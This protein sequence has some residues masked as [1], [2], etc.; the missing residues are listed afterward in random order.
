ML[1]GTVS[2]AT[3]ITCMF[4]MLKGTVSQG[5]VI[6]C[7]FL[8]LK[9]TVSQATLIKCMFLM[10]KGYLPQ[11]T[12][13]ILGVPGHCVFCCSHGSGVISHRAAHICGGGH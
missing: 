10:L 5:T 13:I 3:L 4:L 11:A 2:Q 9:G 8:M 12:L 6:K 1:K 7:T